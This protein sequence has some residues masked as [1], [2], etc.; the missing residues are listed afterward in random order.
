MYNGTG[1]EL[2][3]S[4]NTS[5]KIYDCTLNYGIFQEQ[6]AKSIILILF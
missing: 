6:V 5:V 1:P 2:F 3:S 4:D